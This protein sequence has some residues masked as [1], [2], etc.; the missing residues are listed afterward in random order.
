MLYFQ[1][2]TTEPNL[3]FSGSTN[4][5]LCHHVWVD[6]SHKIHCLCKEFQNSQYEM[7]VPWNHSIWFKT[8][9]GCLCVEWHAIS[10]ND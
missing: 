7:H 9:V 5:H 3:Q 8:T 10:Q 6:P 4:S 1:F 2:H